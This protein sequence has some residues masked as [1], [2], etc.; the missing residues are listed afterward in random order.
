MNSLEF[1]IIFNNCIW[2]LTDVEYRIGPPFSEYKVELHT[3]S[4]IANHK[5]LL[6]KGPTLE[7]AILDCFKGM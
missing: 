1:Q 4:K 6:G 2:H 5:L 7:M 3:E